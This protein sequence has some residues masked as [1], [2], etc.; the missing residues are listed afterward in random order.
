VV[1]ASPRDDSHD[2]YVP[3]FAGEGPDVMGTRRGDVALA[4]IDGSVP[5]LLV[6][7]FGLTGVDTL[8]VISRLRR[9]ARTAGLPV[10]VLTRRDD[11]A[12]AR[13]V[14]LYPDFGTRRRVRSKVASAP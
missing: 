9:S 5:D 7:D 13:T 1:I 11:A 14:H 12:S 8:S 10:L 3:W 2:F 6:V 4:V